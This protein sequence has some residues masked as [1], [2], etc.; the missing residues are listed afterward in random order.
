MEG[1]EDGKVAPS[2][3]IAQPFAS[4]PHD[5]LARAEDGLCRGAAE[6]HQHARRQELDLTREKRRAGLDLLGRRRAVSRRAPID[7]VGDV[8]VLFAEADRCEHA[9]EQLPGAADKGLALQILIA[10][11]RLADHHDAGL[12]AAPGEAEVLRRALQRAAVEPGDQLLQ[13][14]KR[15]DFG[16]DPARRACACGSW[17]CA[18]W[19]CSPS[20]LGRR[21]GRR[22]EIGGSGEAVDRRL[23]DRLVDAH[24]PIPIEQGKRR[25]FVRR[26]HHPVRSCLNCLATPDVLDTG[27]LLTRE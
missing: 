23:A 19:R 15:R 6:K 9:V 13:F 24:G 8:D 11:R 20:R 3:S 18:R 10:T 1:G 4:E 7:S 25:F 12:L 17:R 21:T 14:G 5:A 26:R 27:F 16:A 22:L 2:A